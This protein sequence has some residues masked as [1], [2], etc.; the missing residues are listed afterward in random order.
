MEQLWC[1]QRA[2]IILIE[3]SLIV[4][5]VHV[6]EAVVRKRLDEFG[7]T[8]SS[9]LTID[10]FASVDLVRCNNFFFIFALGCFFFL[11]I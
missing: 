8:P 10:E 2:R 3:P 11:K 7:Q 4:Q 1:W 9:T 6:L 5:M